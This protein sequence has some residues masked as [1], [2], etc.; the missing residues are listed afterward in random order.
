MFFLTFFGFSLPVA[1]GVFSVLP[2]MCCLARFR[3]KNRFVML[4]DGGFRRIGDWEMD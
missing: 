1:G 3:L 4:F 2:L